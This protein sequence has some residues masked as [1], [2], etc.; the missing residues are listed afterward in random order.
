MWQQAFV[1][2]MQSETTWSW[3]ILGHSPLVSVLARN[4]STIGC[5]NQTQPLTT[6]RLRSV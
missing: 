2:P 1:Q 5:H 4:C 6:G 3:S